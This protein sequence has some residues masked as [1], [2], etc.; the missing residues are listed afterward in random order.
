MN[1]DVDWS[2]TVFV[3]CID[4]TVFDI[5]GLKATEKEGEQV[6]R[7]AMSYISEGQRS[8]VEST[9]HQSTQVENHLC[10]TAA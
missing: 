10:K 1:T 7:T 3:T 8:G 6:D 9:T 4:R 5:A 2:G